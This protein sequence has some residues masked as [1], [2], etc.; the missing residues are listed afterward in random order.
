M[1]LFII[2][3]Y[4]ERYKHEFINRQDAKMIAVGE[5]SAGLAHEIRNPLGLIKNYLFVLGD[6]NND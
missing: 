6:K 2:K 5:L 4:T 3:D 1:N